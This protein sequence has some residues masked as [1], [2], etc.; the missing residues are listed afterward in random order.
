MQI[1]KMT[2]RKA[3]GNDG[4]TSKKIQ[5]LNTDTKEALEHLCKEKCPHGL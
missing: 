3:A 5:S 2:T 4:I 1:K